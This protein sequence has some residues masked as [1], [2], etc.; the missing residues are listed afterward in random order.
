MTSSTFLGLIHNAALL[1]AL[2]L[3]YEMFGFRLRQSRNVSVQMVAGL[4][5]GGIGITIML[6]PWNFGSG[7]VFDTRSVLLVVTGFFLGTVP[8]C[9]AMA[10]TGAYRVFLGGSGVNMGVTVILLSGLTGLVWRHLRPGKG[11]PG[12]IELYLMGIVAH[13]LMLAATTLLPAHIRGEVLGSI[14]VPVMSI[15]PLTTA[16]LGNLLVRSEKRRRGEEELRQSEERYRHLVENANSIIL[17]IDGSGRILFANPFASAFFGYDMEEL[18]QRHVVGTIVPAID[19]RGVNLRAVVDDIFSN[20]AE[21]RLYENENIRKDGSSVWVS[22]TNSAICDPSGQVSEVLAVGNDISER[23]RAEEALKE[24]ERNFRSLFA[25]LKDM[26]FVAGNNGRLLTGNDAL[27]QTLGY[28]QG[29]L[30]TM[31]L[32]E[33]FAVDSRDEVRH[34]LQPQNR[35]QGDERLLPLVTRNGAVIPAATVLWSGMWNGQPCVYGACR[36]RRR[37]LEAE[38]RFEQL[39]RH[40]PALMAL[41]R[42]SDGTFADVNDAWLRATGYRR[43]EV[44]GKTSRQLDLFVSQDEQEEAAKILRETGSIADVELT[45]RGRDGSPLQGLFFGERI[46]SG[47]GSHFLTVMLDISE[48]K[49]MEKERLE[50]ETRLQTAHKMEALGTLAG[51]IAHDFNNILGAV[52]GYAE[53]ARE[54]CQD[55]TELAFSIEQIQSAGA[56]AK[57]LVRQI[58]AFSRQGDGERQ[59]LQPALILGET[60]K[61]L[62]ASIPTTI[63]IAAD[64]DRHT[65]PIL[66]TPTQLHQILMNLCTNAAHAMEDQGGMLRVVLNEVDLDEDAAAAHGLPQPGRHLRLS[67]SDSGCGMTAEVRARIFDPYFTTKEQGKGTGMG[68]LAIVHSIV[69]ALGGTIACYSEPGAGSHFEILLPAAGEARV[70]APPVAQQPPGGDERILF[71]DDEESLVRTGTT[72]LQRLG[73]RVTGMTDSRQA[74]AAFLAA[75]DDFDLIVTDHTMPG[76]TGAELAERL[77]AVRPRLPIL[78]C[79]GYSNTMTPAKARLMGIEGFLNK[80]FSKNDIALAIRLLLDGRDEASPAAT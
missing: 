20:P 25:S 3:L 55:G 17:R 74:L 47:E 63:D 2:C 15:Y 65:A 27:R 49:R 58:L 48:R 12:L 14:A 46:G 7:V 18:L 16:I 77:L 64:I 10:M 67:V 62:R 68:L 28:D 54:D 59:P 33:L 75:P 21:Y 70:P 50:L 76:L 19:S 52:I 13:L 39:F 73:Y 69:H 41:T 9:I 29:Q 37:E 6:T 1:L 24:S 35:G 79:T 5:L 23:K 4:I 30:S 45:I 8:T 80:P 26:L 11:T 22:W 60:L 40:N 31:P 36:D 43:E 32:E 34:L 78:L 42:E 51:G 72:M 44:I 56:R 57:D 66:A 61:L 38:R 53:M 71:V